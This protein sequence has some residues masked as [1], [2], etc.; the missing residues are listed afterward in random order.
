MM[1]NLALVRS[2][3]VRARRCGVCDA[4]EV[5]RLTMENVAHRIDTETCHFVHINCRICRAGPS[6]QLS[7]RSSSFSSSRRKEK[8]GRARDKSDIEYFFLFSKLCDNE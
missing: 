1:T 5:Q 6:A 4:V 3:E 7:N 2:C 8:E